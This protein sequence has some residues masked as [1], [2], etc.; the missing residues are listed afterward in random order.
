MSRD[1]NT[2]EVKGILRTSYLAMAVM[3]KLGTLKML[4]RNVGNRKE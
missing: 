2:V 1:K 4:L 3:W